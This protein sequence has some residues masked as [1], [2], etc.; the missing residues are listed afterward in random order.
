MNAQRLLRAA[1]FELVEE[2][3]AR[4]LASLCGHGRQT[5]YGARHTVRVCDDC[6]RVLQ[7]Q[8]AP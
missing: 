4:I 7:V 2:M 3:D 1:L 5:A 6:N 8:E